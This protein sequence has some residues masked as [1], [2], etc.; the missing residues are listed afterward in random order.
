MI[1]RELCAAMV[2]VGAAVFG[3]AGPSLAPPASAADGGMH[4]AAD[5]PSDPDPFGHDEHDGLFP[6]CTGCHLGAETG[7]EEL[8]Y[9][10]PASCASCHDGETEERVDWPGPSPLET[11][12]LFGHGEHATWTAEAGDDSLGCAACHGDPEPAVLA[13]PVLEADGCLT[14]HEDL[15]GEV[16]HYVESD[17]ATCHVPAASSS[18]GF[19]RLAELPVPSDHEAPTYLAEVHGPAA[20]ARVENRCATCHVANQCADCHVNAV[21]V[22]EIG[23]LPAEP[24]ARPFPELAADYPIP[25][26][27]Q[28]PRFAWAHATALTT[29]P[30]ETPGSASTPTF[31]AGGASAPDEAGAACATCHTRE[32][33][34]ACHLAPSPEAVTTLV[35]AGESEAPGAE[36]VAE[37]PPTHA[38]PF[39]GERHGGA[40]ATEENACATCHRPE[41]FCAACHERQAEGGAVYH[42]PGYVLGHAAE[43]AQGV[44]ECATCH[45]QAA[46]CRSCHEESGLGSRGRLGSGFHDAEPLWLLRHAQPARQQLESCASC[47]EQRDCL[48]CHSELGSFQISPH[49]P[50]FD[51]RAAQARNPVVCRA[52]HL[53][54]PFGGGDR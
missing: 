12:V 4:L 36:F 7:E 43:A 35:P 26:S 51:A 27:H 13:D 14:C 16:G 45:D 31:R 2:L 42:H 3:L 47:H 40:A 21:R 11:N 8:L 22:T 10:D 24:P 44:L 38:S 46:F 34:R 19:L 29:L 15:A 23:R 52:C 1:P 6:L 5:P 18:L 50:D 49:G 48:Q 25:E 53:G 54:D 41:S 9:P 39:F 30:E 32:Q 28:R 33:C 17:C 37:A 20:E